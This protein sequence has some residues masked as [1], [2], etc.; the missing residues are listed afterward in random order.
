ML[1]LVENDRNSKYN[2]LE[3]FFMVQNFFLQCCTEI[4]DNLGFNGLQ[5]GQ[6]DGAVELDNQYFARNHRYQANDSG[7]FTC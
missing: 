5:E 2:N 6:E 1:Y 4:L 7:K 3:L